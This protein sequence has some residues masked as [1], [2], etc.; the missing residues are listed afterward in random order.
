MYETTVM[1]LCMHVCRQLRRSDRHEVCVRELEQVSSYIHA[2]QTQCMC[3]RIFD[4]SWAYFQ[5][6]LVSQLCTMSC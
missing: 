6:K 2:L 1:M 4:V 3:I 5:V